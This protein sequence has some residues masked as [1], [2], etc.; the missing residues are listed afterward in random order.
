[1]SPSKIPSSES[2]A[3]GVPW[4]AYAGRNKPTLSPTPEETAYAIWAKAHSSE[5]ALPEV[6]ELQ[7]KALHSVNFRHKFSLLRNVKPDGFHDILGEVV[8]KHELPGDKLTVYLSDYTKNSRFYNQAWGE[9]DQD[10][11]EDE[12]DDQNSDSVK[13]HLGP[14]GQHTIQLTLFDGHARYVN[15]TVEP[16]EWILLSN[17]QIKEARMGGL[18]EGYLRSDQS[19]YDGRRRVRKLKQQGDHDDARWKEALGR[20]RDYWRKFK[21]QQKAISNK[22]A[23]LSSKRKADDEDAGPLKN[24]KQRRKEKRAAADKKA[25]ELATKAAANFN[26]YSELSQNNIGTIANES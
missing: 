14:Y 8:K 25:A 12:D 3:S 19:D 9:D 7:E 22:V 17:V 13:R 4:I 5:I 6:I 15:E 18:L 21:E 1:M 20:K 11:L 26:E 10:G 23:G 16:G 24:S 2:F